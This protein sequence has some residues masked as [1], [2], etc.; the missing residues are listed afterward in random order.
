MQETVAWCGWTVYTIYYDLKHWKIKLL[1]FLLKHKGW[2]FTFICEF[3]LPTTP[4]SQ[5]NLDRT[6]VNVRGPV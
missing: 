2:G 6:Q 3:S 5:Y 4:A 1:A